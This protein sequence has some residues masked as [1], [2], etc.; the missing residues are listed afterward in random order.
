MK[1][2]SSI[3][4]NCFTREFRVINEMISTFTH[5]DIYRNCVNRTVEINI[6]LKLFII[7]IIILNEFKSTSG[8]LEKHCRGHLHIKWQ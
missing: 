7:Q 8:Y 2:F 4:F 3:K 6:F 1:F 5:S